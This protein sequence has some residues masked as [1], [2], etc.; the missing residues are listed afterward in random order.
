[1]YESTVGVFPLKN[2]GDSSLNIAYLLVLLLELRRNAASLKYNFIHDFLENWIILIILY[3]RES[4]YDVLD[5]VDIVECKLAHEP[6]VD[7]KAEMLPILL[8]LLALIANLKRVAHDRN[9]HIQHVDNDDEAG[10]PE[11]QIQQVF[12]AFFTHRKRTQFRLAKQHVSNV[13]QRA[14]KRAIG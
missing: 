9:Q 1:M 12:H 14:C 13:I 3:G 11:H 10:S 7:D 6:V 8:L 4:G 2:F 5:L